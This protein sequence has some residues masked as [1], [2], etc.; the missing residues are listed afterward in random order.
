MNF[1]MMAEA[2]V[3]PQPGDFHAGWVTPNPSGAQ[4]WPGT[5]SW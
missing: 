1:C 2:A 3:V 4:G 5:L